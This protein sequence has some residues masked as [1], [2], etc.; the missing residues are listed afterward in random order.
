MQEAFGGTFMLKLFMVFF[1]IYVAFIG[2]A[3]NFA[4][5]YRIK[6]NVI[7]ILEQY[8]YNGQIKSESKVNSELANY[9]SKVPYGYSDPNG[10][11]FNDFCAG[12]DYTLYTTHGVCAI[13]K[14]DEN[15]YYY[16]VKVFYVIDFPLFDIKIPISASGETIVIDTE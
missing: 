16:T 9:L 3:L 5:I 14:G 6:N 13:K 7:N 8:Q 2:V 15:K 12:G 10:T 11:K 1:I 4:K